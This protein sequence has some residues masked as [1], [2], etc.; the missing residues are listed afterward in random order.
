MALWDLFRSE[1]ERQLRGVVEPFGFE[2]AGFQTKGRGAYC[3]WLLE[4]ERAAHLKIWAEY[5]GSTMSYAVLSLERPGRRGLRLTTASMYIAKFNRERLA[6]RGELHVA[7]DARP[8]QQEAAV[9]EI[10]RQLRIAL[11]HLPA[12]LA[13]LRERDP[14]VRMR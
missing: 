13:A 4:P 7:L 8:G 3:S 2:Y 5:D 11:P 12:M 1:C 14:D 10:A 9:A 6:D